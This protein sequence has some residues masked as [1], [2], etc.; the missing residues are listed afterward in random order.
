MSIDGK[1]LLIKVRHSE[2]YSTLSDAFVLSNTVT[3]CESHFLCR[4]AH[5]KGM[6]DDRRSWPVFVGVV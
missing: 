6:L 3:Y 2:V 4:C 1:C 5:A